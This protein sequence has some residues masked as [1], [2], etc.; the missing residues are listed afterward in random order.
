MYLYLQCRHW[1]TWETRIR[2]RRTVCTVCQTPPPPDSASFGILSFSILS[3]SG[4]FKDVAM[5][6]LIPALDHNQGEH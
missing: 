4:P 6:Y 5:S 2:S 3:G 1:P